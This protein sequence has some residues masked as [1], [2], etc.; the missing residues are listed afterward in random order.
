MNIQ[1]IRIL[2]NQVKRFVHQKVSNLKEAEKWFKEHITMR[3]DWDKKEKYSEMLRGDLREGVRK[4]VWEMF[5]QK[6]GNPF[7]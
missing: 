7:E 3:S 1:R 6:Y 2:G 5:Q 4:I